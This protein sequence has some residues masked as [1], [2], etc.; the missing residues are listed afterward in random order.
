MLPGDAPPPP[1]TDPS[2]AGWPTTPP[3][4]PPGTAWPSTPPPAP[5]GTYGGAPPTSPPPLPPT[6]P[7]GPGAPGRGVLIAVV[8]VVAVLALTATAVAVALARRSADGSDAASPT[9][10][11]P[12]APT[13]TR[14]RSGSGGTGGTPGAAPTPPADPA[15]ITRR[16]EEIKRFVERERGLTYKEDVAVQVLD[17]QA[18]KDRVLQEFDK[19]RDSLV[20]QGRLLQAAGLLPADLD[21]VEAQRSLLGE[22]VLGFYDPVSKA[23]VVRGTADTPFLREIMA[24]ELTH[25]LDDQHF[26]LDRPDLT[27]RND[28]SDWA[29]LALVEGNARRVE[30]AY[31]AQM[32]EAERQELQQN[33]LE[34]GMGQIGSLTSTPLVLPQLLM[35]PYDYG[36][37]FVQ[38]VLANGGQARLDAAFTAPPTSSEQIVEPPR[39]DAGDAPKTVARPPADGP[40][41]DEGVLGELLT[42]FI[43]QGDASAGGLEGLLG[44]LLGGT[45]GSSGG[46]GGT[47]IDPDQALSQLTDLLNKLL[48]GSGDPSDLEGLLGGQGG[49][50]ALPGGG[51]DPLGGLGGL[52]GGQGGGSGSLNSLLAPPLQKGWGGDRYVVWSTPSGGSCLRFDWVGDTPTAAAS[53]QTALAKRA[54]SDPQITLAQPTPDT[55]RFTR[56]TA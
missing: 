33:Q 2:G 47:A 24:H 28:G 18:F 15:T 16:A 6:T 55:V 4:G 53:L 29:F 11:A 3:P 45:G 48:S 25:A 43:A 14:P 31:V 20:R 52:L 27:Q 8:A 51:D 54:A 37:P 23:L 32:S 56:C 50:P 40:V 30:Y 12:T 49:G 41:V 36:E 26:G 17:E 10:T 9:T 35:A 1:P 44:G 13:T 46:P 21:A 34:L 22:G 5:P 38:H 7:P 19:E 42:S 39:F